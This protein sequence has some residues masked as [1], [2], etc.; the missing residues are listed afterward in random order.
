MKIFL[1]VKLFREGKPFGDFKWSFKIAEKSC[2]AITPCIFD[3]SVKPFLLIGY[4]RDN[5]NCAV[6]LSVSAWLQE[7]SDFT[8]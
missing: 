5:V 2:K 7:F 1:C 3:N 4:C 6:V 8:T